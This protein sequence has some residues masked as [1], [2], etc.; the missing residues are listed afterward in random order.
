MPAPANF[1]LQAVKGRKVIDSLGNDVGTIE[2]IVIEPGAWKVSGFLVSLRRDL[3]DRLHVER[4]GML[5]NPRIEIG[6]NRVQTVGDNV[7]LNIA[8]DDI[9]EALRDRAP[10]SPGTAEPFMPTPYETTL[11]A[12][13]TMAPPPGP[14]EPPRY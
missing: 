11:P 9:A 7:I 4:R 8:M 10:P 3:A 1:N 13:E 2:D 14:H 5:A 6:S 12:P